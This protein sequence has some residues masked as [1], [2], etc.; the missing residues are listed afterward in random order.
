MIV[1]SYNYALI[2]NCPFLE[3]T[4]TVE[5]LLSQTHLKIVLHGY[6]QK[7]ISR[8]SALSEMF[9]NDNDLNSIHLID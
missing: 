9:I 2:S 3:F 8:C 5:I 4:H 6:Y 7:I 1:F